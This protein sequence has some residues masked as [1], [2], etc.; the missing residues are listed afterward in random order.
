[1]LCYRDICHYTN[2]HV[3]TCMHA[4]S[5]RHRSAPTHTQVH[6]NG[7]THIHPHRH[8]GMCT[9]IHITYT[10]IIVKSKKIWKLR[11]GYS[12]FEKQY[13]VKVVGSIAGFRMHQRK[14]VGMLPLEVIQ[15]SFGPVYECLSPDEAKAHG[16]SLTWQGLQDRGEY[17]WECMAWMLSSLS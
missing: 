8:T 4:C 7:H 3:H 17:C 9:H 10:Q 12:N 16:D 2:V 1:M 14:P 15:P 13:E 5:H 6:M 11:W